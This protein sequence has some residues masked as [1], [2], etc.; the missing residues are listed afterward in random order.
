MKVTSREVSQK[1][2]EIGFRPNGVN[3]FF[4]D[5]PSYYLETILEALPKSST[6]SIE[7]VMGISAGISYGRIIGRSSDVE[8]ELI[9]REENESLADTAARLLL[10]LHEKGIVK[11]N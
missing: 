10:L 5:H 3:S 6:H 11:F 7:L 1:L 8:S 2:K 9:L 4:T